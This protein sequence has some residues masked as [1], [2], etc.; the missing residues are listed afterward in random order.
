VQFCVECKFEVGVSGKFCEVLC[1][2]SGSFELGE[3]GLSLLGE[4][5]LV[6]ERKAFNKL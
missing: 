4:V 3:E 5:G 1:K 6:G 2:S